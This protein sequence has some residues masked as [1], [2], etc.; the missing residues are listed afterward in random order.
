VIVMRS[1]SKTAL[2]WI[3]LGTAVLS[4]PAMHLDFGTVVPVRIL[5]TMEGGEPLVDARFETQN[6]PLRGREGHELRTN[7]VGVVH[8]NIPAYGY[9]DVAVLWRLNHQSRGPFEI[10]ARTVNGAEYAVAVVG[11]RESYVTI[12]GWR[13]HRRDYIELTGL[14]TRNSALKRSAG[15]GWPRTPAIPGQ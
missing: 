14:A 11:F 10:R 9:A 4:V 13:P 15:L 12:L 3:L 2:I 6:A 5:V 8:A 1:R 7:G